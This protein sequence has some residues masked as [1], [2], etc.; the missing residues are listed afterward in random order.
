MA[1]PLASWAGPVPPLSLATIDQGRISI[2]SRRDDVVIVHFFAT[3]C[4]ACR[5]ELGALER[6]RS[7]HKPR[8][9]IVAISVNEP[10]SRVRRYFEKFPVGFPIALDADSSAARR[11]GVFA[12]PSSFVLDGSGAPLLKAAGEVD[13]DGA[14]VRALLTGPPR[15]R[16]AS[17]PNTIENTPTSLHKRTT[18]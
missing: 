6:L 18:P 1:E 5:P 3:W 12:L 10:A 11:W 2:T 7:T 4:E 9:A 15:R 16:G 14:G 8:V 13:W 17:T